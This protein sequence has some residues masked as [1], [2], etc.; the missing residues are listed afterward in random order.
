MDTW[1]ADEIRDWVNRM[2]INVATQRQRDVNEAQAC[3]IA[4]M[5]ADFL[6]RTRLQETLS[7]MVNCFKADEGFPNEAFWTEQAVK[8]LRRYAVALR[9]TQA[10]RAHL[11]QTVIATTSNRTVSESAESAHDDGDSASS[12]LNPEN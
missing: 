7:Y 5:D 3:V 4:A 2:P 8:R 6:A 11:R 10:K 9:T 1:D 12:S